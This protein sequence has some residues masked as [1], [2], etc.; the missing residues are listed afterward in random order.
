MKLFIFMC[1]FVETVESKWDMYLSKHPVLVGP[2]FI[3]DANPYTNNNVG[4]I[5]LALFQNEKRELETVL[6]LAFRVGNKFISVVS[7]ILLYRKL[8][9]SS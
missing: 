4:Q 1:T 6:L 9:K 5:E 2:L 7:T 3:T 8:K